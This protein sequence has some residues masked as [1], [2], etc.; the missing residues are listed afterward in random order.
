M[1]FNLRFNDVTIA[2]MCSEDR[3]WH[4]CVA[5]KADSDE[6]TLNLI[7][8]SGGPVVCKQGGKEVEGIA[9][10][11]EPTFKWVPDSETGFQV[12]IEIDRGVYTR[13]D[14][15]VE[16]IEAWMEGTREIKRNR[17]KRHIIRDLEQAVSTGGGKTGCKKKF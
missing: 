14:G 11:N 3:D 1:R 10:R 7:G 8:D 5:K 4:V 12:S 9:S 15:F 13:A 2:A 17:L 16:W 6:G